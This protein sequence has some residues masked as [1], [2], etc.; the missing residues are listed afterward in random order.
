MISNLAGPPATQPPVPSPV[1]ERAGE[2][3]VCV[4]LNEQGGTTWRAGSRFIKW[5]PEG[6]HE[7]L[8]DE[9]MRLRWLE[10][11]FAAPEALEFAVED[12]GELLV[13][14]ALPG[15]GAVTDTWRDRPQDAV[16]AIA[17]G[18]RRLHA[19]DVADCP[20]MAD[21]PA[22]A[23]DDL[24]VAHGDACAPNT[25]IAPDGAFAGIV[26][27]AR[28]GAADRWLD[29]SVA[30]MSLQWNYGEGLEPLFFDAYGIEPNAERIAFWR[31]WWHRG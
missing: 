3:P 20:F 27:V 25:V 24:V 26:D 4:W 11:R 18:L 6:S 8:G 29:L 9:F 7:S 14:Q 12:D 1:A 22:N 13:T 28:L 2:A 17:T 21:A 31:D 16:R 15:E 30:S 10:G 23:D 19:L 5:N